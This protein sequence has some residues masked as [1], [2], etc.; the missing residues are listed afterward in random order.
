MLTIL[1]RRGGLLKGLSNYLMEAPLLNMV[2]LATHKLVDIHIL[3]LRPHINLAQPLHMALAVMHMEITLEHPPHMFSNK[4]L[5][6]I[7]IC[8]AK[9]DLQQTHK[10]YLPDGGGKET[11]VRHYHQSNR[12]NIKNFDF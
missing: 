6:T 3:F 4:R 1:Y 2:T 7:L 9:Q 8:G 12:E 11:I 5:S 10:E